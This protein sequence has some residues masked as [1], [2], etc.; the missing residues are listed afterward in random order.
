MSNRDVPNPLRP[1]YRPPSINIPRDIPGTTSAGTHGLGPKNGSAAAYASSA[2]RDMLE[3]GDYLTD[4]SPSS[5]EAVR[6]T[7]DDWMYKYFGLLLSQPFEVAKT[8]LQVRSQG[9]SDGGTSFQAGKDMPSNPSR[10]RGSGYSGYPS[11]DSDPDE[12]AY[13]TSSAPSAAT[14]SPSRQRRRRASSGGESPVSRIPSCPSHQLSLKKADSLLEVI[15][16]EWAT[17]GA[18]GVWKASN[19]TFLYSILLQTLEQWSRGLLSGIFNVPDTVPGLSISANLADSPYPWASLAVSIGAAVGAGLILA[20]LDLVRTKLILTST[21]TPKRSL[22]H[23]VRHLPSYFCPANLT[24][25]TILH[26]FVTPTINHSTPLLLRSHLGIDPILTPTTYSMAT[27]MLRTAELF[28]KLPLETVL[29]RGQI[30]VLT[31]PMRS[32][33]SDM[34]LKTVVEPGP[35]KGVL[36]TMWS[37]VYEEGTPSSLEPLVKGTTIQ[38]ARRGNKTLK[39]GQGIEGLWRGWRVGMWG[40]IGMWGARAMGGSGGNPREF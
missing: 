14:S 1:Y 18:W 9:D 6:K 40:L 38:S 28:I 11:D 22:V 4:S 25:P 8:I 10:H 19:A 35:Y 20:P 26:S 32:M 34:A 5:V 12:P 31:N 16:Q 27:F 2:A 29:R 33:G 3:Y 21:S 17:E 23:N 13:F 30:A 39:K 24:I 37:I 15:S 36:G 7:L